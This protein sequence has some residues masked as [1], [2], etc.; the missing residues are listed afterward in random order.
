M[1]LMQEV[2]P[3][4]EAALAA[5]GMIRK[6]GVTDVI[7]H[8]GRLDDGVQRT[9]EPFPRDQLARKGVAAPPAAA[10]IIEPT[11]RGGGPQG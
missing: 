7:V 5:S 4:V 6:R 11:A 3:G 1:E 9:G 10:S 8:H 2:R